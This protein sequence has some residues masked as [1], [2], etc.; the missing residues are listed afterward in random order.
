MSYT[1]FD[2]EH[3]FTKLSYLPLETE[4]IGAVHCEYSKKLLELMEKTVRFRERQK[5]DR[6]KVGDHNI[7]FF[8]ET[9]YSDKF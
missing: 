3:I 6:A 5:N 9:R 8:M 1:I 2:S 4:N 7:I